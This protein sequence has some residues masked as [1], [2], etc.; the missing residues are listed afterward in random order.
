MDGYKATVA[1]VKS[2]GIQ[3]TPK[4]INIFHHISFAYR[5]KSKVI[6]PENSTQL[7]FIEKVT[8]CVFFIIFYLLIII[9]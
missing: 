8:V 3:K 2:T 1:A 9:L 5:W 7:Q 4:K 6:I